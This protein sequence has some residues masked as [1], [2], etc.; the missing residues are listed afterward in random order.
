M[1]HNR[2][3]PAIRVVLGFLVTGTLFAQAGAGDIYLRVQALYLA[4]KTAQ[5]RGD[6]AEAEAK[7]EQILRVAPNLAAAY[8]NLGALYFRER[9]YLKAAAVLEKGLNVNPGMASARALLGIS[10][11]NA[12]E[13]A[14]ARPSLEAAVRAN[15]ADVNARLFLAKDLTKLALFAAASVELEKL[16]QQNPKNQEVWYLLAKLHMRMSEEALARMNAID[17]NSALAHQLSGEVMESMNNYDGAVVELKKAVELAPAVPG[18]H[19][20]L[21]DAYW[22]LSQWDSAAEQ[23]EAELHVDPASCAAQWKL[24]N[25][26]LQKNGSAEDALTHINEALTRCPAMTDARV[27]R[28]RALALAGRGGEA[29]ADLQAAAK[30]SPSDAGIHFLLGKVYRSL[31][32]TQEAQAEMETF[33]KLDE[34]ARAATAERAQEVIKNK[35]SA[36]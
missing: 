11:F 15:P 30:A 21:G 8:N 19:Y 24:G 18:N 5:D 4:A 14:K 2:N 1:N 13:Y 12:G 26:I 6:L 10:L 16:G 3:V 22:T 27:D 34:A 29:L 25:V 35:E 31:G 23:F 17:S 7:Y 9:D 28:A 33:A 36:R 20:R 32:R